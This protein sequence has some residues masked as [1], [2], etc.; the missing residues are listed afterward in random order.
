M[1]VPEEKDSGG[2]NQLPV[3]MM[4]M[5]LKLNFKMFYFSFKI[6]NTVS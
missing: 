5:E 1:D 2:K 3:L 4:M 6:Q